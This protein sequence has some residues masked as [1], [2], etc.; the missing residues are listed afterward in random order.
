MFSLLFSFKQNMQLLKCQNK[1]LLLNDMPAA[2]R[3]R[4]VHLEVTEDLYRKHFLKKKMKISRILP[5]TYA[6]KPGA[7]RNYKLFHLYKFLIRNK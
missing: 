2:R 5:G 4:E 3:L 6:G 7:Q 1:M